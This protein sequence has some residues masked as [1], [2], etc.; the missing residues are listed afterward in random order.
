MIQTVF[1]LLLA[2][3]WSAFPQSLVACP[4][5]HATA[6]FSPR[7][8]ATAA[9][10]DALQ[11]AQHTVLLQAYSF[12]S[13]PIAKAL[14]AAHARGVTVLAILDK[15]NAT[16]KYSAATFLAHAGI[17]PLI[18]ADHAIAHSKVLVIDDTTVITGSF[19]FSKAAEERN[20]ENLVVLTA[21]PALAAA[22]TQEVRAHV[23]HARPYV[24]PPPR[25]PGG[26]R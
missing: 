25:S 21:A 13:V 16:D 6:Y 4:N 19:N 7:G 26:R 1:L 10:V 2:F 5:A 9:I 15:S 18:D 24:V 22:Y 17:T 11:A 20:A 12:T 23:A 8:G 3:M 14:V